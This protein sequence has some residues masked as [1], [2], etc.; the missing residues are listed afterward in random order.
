M[1][2]PK[3]ADP[4]VQPEGITGE[5]ATGP[6][7][8]PQTIT[9]LS[10]QNSAYRRLIRICEEVA[11][12]ALHG[13][14]VGEL[15][16]VLA[17]ITMKTI[18]LL[19]PAFELRCHAVGHGSST[20]VF[21]WDPG[22]RVIA[23]LL[24]SL[25][26]EHLPLRVPAIPDSILT[27]GCLASPI[28]L[29][30]TTLGYL[31]IMES[32]D[33]R[34]ADDVN[35]LIA[36]YVATLFAL[37]LAHERTSTD[38]GRRYQAATVDS[39]V[40]GHFL[41]LADARRKTHILGLASNQRYRIAVIRA[42]VEQLRSRPLTSDEIDELIEAITVSVVGAVGAARDS[43]LVLILPED[44]DG[45]THQDQVATGMR[46]AMTSLK[47]WQSWSSGTGPTCGLSESTRW[48]DRAPLLLQQAETAIEIGTRIG[49]AGQ[50]VP[51]DSLG[52]YK[53]LLQIGDIQQLR[54]FAEEV[55]G[56]LINYDAS[57]KID[58][59]RTLSV[60]LSQRESLKRTASR[61]QVHT[62]TVSYRI[63]RIEQLSRLDLTDPDDQLLA[64]ISVKIIEAQNNIRQHH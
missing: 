15:T 27:H 25:A 35:L 64:H 40:S 7:R 18:V 60:Y 43:S 10:R 47:T 16:S 21:E 30:E 32:D 42:H 59:V 14:D 26:T 31:L 41:D 19:N 6:R 22:D 44:L 24:D 2:M 1:I 52:I 29:G 8:P 46:A 51:Y 11:T 39:L 45:T 54:Q 20:G 57:H 5:R 23:R 3:T 61:L 53:L 17:R 48:P 38:L 63:Q 12:A 36:S 55:L 34:D 9:G 58:L 56:P 4:P 50:I 13:A 49:R 62:N 28:T 33:T 37:T